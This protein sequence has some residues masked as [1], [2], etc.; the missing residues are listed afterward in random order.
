MDSRIKQK[1]QK[2]KF[3]LIGLFLVVGIRLCYVWSL[4]NSI[5]HWRDG[6]SYDNIARNMLEGKGFRDTSGEWPGEPP[7]AD[8]SRPTAYWLPG[9]PVFVSLVYSV[10]GADFMTVYIFQALHSAHRP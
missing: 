7:F 1:A 4:P 6:I 2:N 8:P 9:Y 5:D 3:L 10:F